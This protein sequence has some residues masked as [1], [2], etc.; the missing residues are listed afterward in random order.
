MNNFN[1]LLQKGFH[2]HKKNKF[3]EAIKIY[4]E[5]FEKDNNNPQLNLFIGTLYIQTKNY[6]KAI[7]YLEQCLKIDKYN[8]PATNNLAVAYERIDQIENA[9]KLYLKSLNIFENNP[10]TNFRIANLY[11][12]S[13]DFERAIKYYQKTI[14]LKPDFINAYINLGNIFFKLEK[15]EKALNCFDEVIKLDDKNIHAFLSR[16]DIYLKLNNY[17]YAINNYEEI[18]KIDPFHDLVL[19]KLLF[20]KMFIHDWNNYNKLLDFIVKNID[21]NLMVIHPSIFLSVIDQ[22]DLHLKASKIYHN[23]SYKGEHNEEKIELKK[24]SKINVGYFSSDFYNHATLRLM[25]DVFQHHDKSKFRIFGFSYGPKKNDNYTKKFKTYLD[26]YH[27][28]EDMGFKEIYSICKKININIAVDLK[29]YTQHNKINIFKKRIA[30]IQISYLGYPG[31][32]GLDNMDYILA[33]KVIIPDEST[34]FYTEKI[35]HLPDCYQPN[36]KHKNI[37]R[38]K[39]SKKDFGLNED[40]FIFCSFNFNYKITPNIFNIWINI[41]KQTPNSILW[42][43]VSN[44]T[45]KKNLKFYAESNGLDPERI[46]FAEYLSESEHLARLKLADIFLDTFPYNAHTT[47]SD[48]IRMGVPIITIKGKSFASRVAAS[49]LHQFGLDELI[50]INEEKY[51][52]KAI[53]LYNQPDELKKLRMK[54]IENTEKSSLFNSEKITRNLEKVY[55]IVLNKK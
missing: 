50:M 26:D 53:K 22:P 54:L 16:G 3:N 25:M 41:L 15:F 2:L 23:K 48:A 10:E 13:K 1:R 21:K 12:K 6:Q 49:I 39:K 24:N 51:K 37:S 28:I 14:N 33:D 4:N 20:A 7:H 55:S 44:K 46:V 43:L 11:L 19:G 9:L 45:A 36:E 27:H 38:N 30:P 42:I 29:G 35:L 34:K 52:N 47:A 32:T 8:T 5:L 40:K 18:I 17:T 31:T